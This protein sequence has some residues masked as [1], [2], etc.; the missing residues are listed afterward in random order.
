FGL[1]AEDLSVLFRANGAAILDM[2][3]LFY[4]GGLRLGELCH[5]T[6]RQVRNSVLH[7]EPHDGW[8]PKWG[9]SRSIPMDAATKAMLERRRSANPKAR[10]VFETAT[11]SRFE[12]RNVG[13]DFSKLF[14][15]FG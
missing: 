6:F 9:I 15:K 12:E 5:L 3:L 13:S 4:H 1:K 10:Y 11:G 2:L 7:I 8:I 14:T